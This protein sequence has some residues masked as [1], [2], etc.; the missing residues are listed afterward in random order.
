MK[1][2]STEDDPVIAEIPVYLTKTL[3]DQ[4]YVFQYP[5]RPH[6]H[7]YDDE[8]ILKSNIR[9]RSGQVEIELGLR[10][11]GPTYDKSKGEQIALNVD[12]AYRDKRDS[13][14]NF[15][16]SQ[17]MDKL[18]LT[19]TKVL[20]DA[21]RYAV[22]VMHDSALHLSPVSQVLALRPSFSYLDM[23]EKRGKQER[24]DIT[25]EDDS[26]EEKNEPKKVT[27][28]FEKPETDKSRAAKEKSYGYLQK[29]IREEPW[30]ETTFHRCGTEHTEFEKQK[31]YCS[32]EDQQG[33]QFMLSSKDYLTQLVPPLKEIEVAT[34]GLP[35]HLM[36]RIVLA[37]LP[38]H[39]R[40]RTIINNA[41]VAS[42]SEVV[43]MTGIGISPEAAS[44]LL[45]V[46][47]QVAVLVQGNWVVKSDIIFPKDGKSESGVANELIQR[48]RDYVL[49]M[50][51]KNSSIMRN[52]IAEVVGLPGNDLITIFKGVARRKGNR[53][54]WEFLLP[55]DQNFIK[56]YPDVVQR[57]EMIWQSRHEQL[58]HAFKDRAHNCE[59]TPQHSLLCKQYAENCTKKRDH[60][61]DETDTFESYKPTKENNVEDS[62]I[63]ADA[64]EELDIE[65][66]ITK[67][68]SLPCSPGGKCSCDTD[69]TNRIPEY[70]NNFLNTLPEN[71][72]IITDDDEM[73][74]C[75]NWK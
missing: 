72:V 32:Y 36:S 46:L 4:L 12:G 20:N 14:D 19:S 40:C 9:P 18:V 71:T 6:S 11:R 38:L 42:F 39:E 63:T 50:L 60:I 16:Q 24:K 55:T 31:L 66:I 43:A 23:A 3:T 47:Q 41:G 2:E 67:L 51:S 21:S 13:E 34:P 8:T 53:G 68:S 75:N 28:R 56:K 37:A 69:F 7:S 30:I 73:Y 45:K 1:T 59:P 44:S 61:N 26:D 49:Y 64:D 10:T 54:V 27:V 29:Q 52:E 62:L 48:G 70:M 58:S 17:V 15:Y 5:V 35:A 74:I 22:G 65:C 25:G 33:D 57:Q